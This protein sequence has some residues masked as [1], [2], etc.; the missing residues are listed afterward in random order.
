M[1][2]VVR[3]KT[4]P[5]AKAKPTRH[6]LARS[7]SGMFF[8]IPEPMTKELAIRGRTAIKAAAT[9]WEKADTADVA[10]QE[11]WEACPWTFPWSCPGPGSSGGSRG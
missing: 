2:K 11:D 10:G 8:A 3:K 9:A 4:L 7:K 1:S 5:K 6:I